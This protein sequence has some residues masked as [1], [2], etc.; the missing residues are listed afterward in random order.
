[1]ENTAAFLSEEEKQWVHRES[2][3]ILQKVG[4]RF[5][6]DKALGILADNG[7]AVDRENH[8]AYIPEEMVD[9][10][11]RLAPRSF[12]LGARDPERDFALPAESMGTVLDSG[13]IFTLDFH[14]GQRRPCT[15]EDM[16]QQNKV[17][18]AGEFA[19]VVWPATISD[20]FPDHSRELR[21]DIY[22]FFST[23]LHVQS[24]LLTPAE[25]P[26]MAEALSIILGSEDAV[27][28]RKIYSLVYCPIPPLGHDKK[29]CETFLET[30][31]LEMPICIY[32]MPGAGSTGPASLFSTAALGNAEAL[33]SL[34]LFQMARPGTP[35][36]FGDAS[37]ATNFRTGGFLEGAPE[38]VLITAARGEM[39]R[40]YG[41]PNEQAGLLTDAVAH[42]NQAILEK[43]ITSL[44]LIQSGVDLLQGPG[45]IETSNTITLEQIV[46][47]DEI[48]RHGMRIRQ[49]IASR[50]EKDLSE[51]IK[52]VGPGGHFL[53]QPATVAACRGS[54]FMEP[55]LTERTS[56]E[57][58]EE[59]GRPD[60]Y[61][62]AHDRVEAILAGPE[63]YPLP[64]DIKGKLEDL[65]N[66][67]DRELGKA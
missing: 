54:E 60:M 19:N 21:Q 65:M 64:D 37:G 34:V 46:V 38:M 50:P 42:G 27:R 56:Y 48:V 2:L 29:M 23:S 6:S 63:R 58:W 14:T 45:A 62:R 12:V 1:M 15:L 66:R 57:D 55:A 32:P 51:D 31:P 18:E 35:C 40:F 17:Y 49:G 7:A 30:L 4:V 22:A 36:I 9:E 53:M 39:A 41:L 24:E 25:V 52:E 16:H 20:P 11:L 5:P 13:G 8:I 47:D 10:A 43:T 44:P 33:S 28:E 26:L 3:K 61:S 67:A 59:Q